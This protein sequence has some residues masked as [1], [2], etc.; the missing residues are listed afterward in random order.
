ML[1]FFIAIL[2][3]YTFIK[4]NSL[5][6]ILIVN[7]PKIQEHLDHGIIQNQGLIY[8]HTINYKFCIVNW[9]KRIK[10]SRIGGFL[11]LIHIF[12]HL[13]IPMNHLIVKGKWGV[14]GLWG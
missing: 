7:V 1:Y 13:G 4:N 12:V 10:L 6:L 2:L 3:F 9:M 8:Y 14:K 11:N 5:N